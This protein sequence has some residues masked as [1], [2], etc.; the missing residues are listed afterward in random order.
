MERLAWWL[1]EI[2]CTSIGME[3]S[4]KHVS[5]WKALHM[6]LVVVVAV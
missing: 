6:L 1:I 3:L 5:A 2:E 4:N